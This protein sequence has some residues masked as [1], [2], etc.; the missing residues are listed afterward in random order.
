MLECLND[1]IT[2]KGMFYVRKCTRCLK[3]FSCQELGFALVNS[4]WKSDGAQIVW[5]EA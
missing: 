2:M 3:L 4:E 1:T 5:S